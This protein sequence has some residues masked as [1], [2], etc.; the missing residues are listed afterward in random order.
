MKPVTTHAP[1]IYTIPGPVASPKVF[2]HRTMSHLLYQEGERRERG[3]EINRERERERESER[4]RERQKER[5]T[6]R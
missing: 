2:G 6:E 4:K 1:N 3:R 5:E